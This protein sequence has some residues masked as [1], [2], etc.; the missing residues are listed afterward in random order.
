MSLPLYA[1]VAGRPVGLTLGLTTSLNPFALREGFAEIAKL[2]PA[3]ML[4]KLRD[5]ARRKLI[6]S[7][8]ASP[9]LLEIQPPLNRQIATRWDRMYLLGETPD[10][11]PEA[12]NSVAAIARRTGRTPQE[13][14]L[15][16]VMAEGG[17]GLLMLP[18]E[19]YAYGSLDVVHEMITDPATVLGVPDGGAHVGVICDAS[20]PTS[21]LTLWGRDRK[22]GPKLP[23]EYLVAKQTRGTAEAYNLLDR[24]LLAPGSFEALLSDSSWGPILQDQVLSMALDHLAGTRTVAGYLT[25]NFTGPQLRGVGTARHI[26]R[27]GVTGGQNLGPFTHGGVDDV[28]GRGQFTFDALHVAHDPCAAVSAYQ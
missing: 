17:K 8:E 15:E 26:L 7:Q 20:S 13:V 2:P 25:V 24:G 5:P 27:R 16:I 6:L 28:V 12:E 10:Y 9:R 14:S 18:F 19:N 23:L 21:L 4:A 22:R 11:E 3:E 1:Q